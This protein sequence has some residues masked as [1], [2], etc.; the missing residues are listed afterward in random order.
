M[1]VVCYDERNKPYMWQTSLRFAPAQVP[2][3][4]SVAL[5]SLFS[6]A[7]APGE[8][9]QPECRPQNTLH[10]SLVSPMYI[11]TYIAIVSTDNWITINW[12]TIH[13]RF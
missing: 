6:K 7:D 1:S 2:S 9:I 8:A 10:Y 3:R 11:Y 5:C 12:I 13:Q 4:V